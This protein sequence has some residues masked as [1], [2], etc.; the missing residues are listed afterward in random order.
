MKVA[1][2]APTETTTGLKEHWKC[3]VCGDLFLDEAGT[4]PTTLEQVTL[5]V[6]GHTHSLT[7][8]AAVAA[9]CT[10]D[11]NIE[12]YTCTCGKIFRDAAAAIEIA[13][14]DTVIPAAHTL[15]KVAAVAATCTKDGNIEH[16][17]C[18]VCGK[19]FSDK[20]GEHEITAASV[21][22][23]AA[24]TLVK[25]AAVAPTETTTGL[26]EHWKCSVCG[27]LFLDE[28]GTKPTTLE[29]VTLPKLDPVTE[30]TYTLTDKLEVGKNYL[31]VSAYEN[32]TAYALDNTLGAVS[33]TIADGKI[34]LSNDDVVW[35][36]QNSGSY[37]GLK[38]GDD[39]LSAGSNKIKTT[40]SPDR[41]TLYG[42]YQLTIFKDAGSQSATYY[43]YYDNGFGASYD[44]N[45]K[46]D[47][48]YLFVE[49]NGTPVYPSVEPTDPPVGETVTYTLTHELEAGKE[50]L[51]VNSSADGSAYALLNKVNSSSGSWSQSS[52]M[53]GTAVTISDGKIQLANND[54]VWTSGTN[55]D[56][57][58]F[59]NG[60]KWLNATSNGLTTASSADDVATRT[61]SYAGDQLKLTSDSGSVYV[62]YYSTSNYFNASSSSHQ[63]DN[64]YLFVKDDGSVTPHTHELVHHD[65]KA[66]TTT[67][68]GNIEYWECTSCGKL[69]S[70]AAATHQIS[71]ADTVIPAI[72]ESVV[73]VP[74]TSLEADKE[75]LIVN[76]N[77]G[78]VYVVSNE[79]GAAKQLKGISATVDASGNIT[80][81]ATDAAKA[82]FTAVSKTSDSGSASFWLENGGKYLYTDSSNGLR[83]SAE[84]TGDNTGKFWHYKADGKNLLWFFKDTASSDGYTDN[85]NTYKYY[86]ECSN[87]GIFTDNHASNTPLAST[88]TPAIYLFVK[89]DGTT[90]PTPHTHV[91]TAHVA[92]AATCTEAGNEAYWECTGCGKLFSDAEG[93]TEISAI[94]TTAALGHSFGDWTVVTAATCTKAGSEQRVC[95]KCGEVETREI[96]ATGHGATELK[97][98][99]EATCSAEGYTGDYVC[100]VCGEVVTAGS[101]IAK[102]AHQT[103]VVN[104]K[105]ATC[106]EAGYTGDTVC[107]VCGETVSRGSTI[108]ALG[109]TTELRNAKDPTCTEKGYTGD[110]VCTRCGE[111][112]AYGSDIAALGH[113]W[114]DG[115]VTKQPSCTESGERTFTCK[116]DA[117]HT[118]TETIDALGHQWSEWKVTVQ[119]T[120]TEAGFESRTC[121]RCGQSET[122]EVPPIAHKHVMEAVAAVAAT[123]ET[124]GNEAYWH[125]T[126]C[127][128]YFSDA[129][130]KNEIEAPVV[131]PAL[132]HKT[133]I[134]GAKDPAC[135]EKGYTGDE[136]C[137]VCGKL[138]NK[139]EDIPA[140]GHKTIV[141]GKKD[142]TCTEAGYTGDEVC[143]VC[144]ETVKKGEVIP[145]TGHK[146]GE[147]Q[148]TVP[149]TEDAE[150][151]ETRVCSV[152]G[153][154]ET[155][156]IAPIGHTH[157]M[158]K[159]DE[160]PATCE[161]DGTEAY[162]QCSG[163]GKLFADAE[164]NTEIQAPVV[165]EAPGHTLVKHD[166]VAPTET[167]AGNIEYWECSV[168]HKLF[169]DKD[170]K[171]EIKLEDT[172]LDP[173]G[174][175]PCDGGAN[176]PSIKLTDVDRS[177]T[178]FYHHAVDW[179]YV[180]D[181]VK[182]VDDTH[183]GPK[184][185]CTREMMVTLL[186]RMNG[187]PEP[188]S[189]V[190]PFADVT[191]PDYYSYK[192]ILWA[193][194]NGITKGTD[195]AKKLF[196]PKDNV[197][198]EQ[199]VTLLWRLKG[200]E[201]VEG[202]MQFTDVKEGRYSYEAVKWAV[203]EGITTGRSASS[204]APGENCTRAEIVTFL[205]R[206]SGSPMV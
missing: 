162:W 13:L 174:K 165:I 16:W 178:S 25:V 131:L 50:Y 134:R 92:V 28:A 204:F 156:T 180:N 47:K 68:P 69:Y 105:D 62:M 200:S 73:F 188:K 22:V 85:S 153:E 190:S 110:Y 54:A 194:E 125:C 120:E 45:H 141:Q 98:A 150:G 189:M 154:K 24:H 35:S 146:W 83:M 20:D 129:E 77:T 10:K 198:R 66:A 161:K 32:G 107:S 158:T 201:T 112:I 114:N 182:G 179:A 19:L 64:I 53:S 4:Q 44:D 11:G 118:R 37:V 81:S 159:V 109:H 195:E 99:K 72:G 46:A 42:D 116:H 34:T 59:T 65:A 181:I 191:N 151:V 166:A 94:P 7:K 144:G 100:T 157:N 130:G 70:D 184:T 186:W 185:S 133:E 79:A 14:K 67:E 160:V 57:F 127:N 138:L 111:T 84:P 113:E 39:W 164:G 142:A 202:A 108:P 49:G 102:L 104:K 126:G 93:K 40:S 128:K 145:A 121:S 168:C 86:L 199:V 143:T 155:R 87:A 193:A 74:A 27:D 152:C 48:V 119:P 123:C 1:A 18:S 33:V 82:T 147:W 176:C 51:I 89:N 124:A 169:S 61:W 205:W 26:K 96:A 15:E 9:T 203:Q 192:A 171:N 106:T 149:A 12:Y 187:S 55:A 91:L 63:S 6:A 163:C 58:T 140:L 117:S 148:V 197:T 52:N 60:G 132:G 90:P 43:V 71:L 29:E 8:V 95:S 38:N 3:S 75:Y 175:Q 167:E 139:G 41:T 80:L 23:P 36:A 172:I 2:V 173:T 5:P 56:G 101:A 30:V 17:K 31:V 78:A 103:Q 21:V 76:G 97:N 115:V 206:F 137:S 183:F 170:G 88:D 136:Y 177:A 135:A 122:R 196:S